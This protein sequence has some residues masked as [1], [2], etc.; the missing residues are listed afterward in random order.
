MFRAITLLVAAIGLIF[1]AL[2]GVGMELRAQ[3]NSIRSVQTINFRD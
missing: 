1:P 2:T 3:G